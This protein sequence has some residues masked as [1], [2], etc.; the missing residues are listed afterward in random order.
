MERS[1]LTFA[2]VKKAKPASGADLVMVGS[3]GNLDRDGD[4]VKQNFDLKHYRKNPVVLW[5]HRMGDLPI[6]KSVKVG[7]VGKGDAK[8]L[9][10]HWKFVPGDVYPFAEAVKALYEGGFLNASSIGFIPLETKEHAPEV[11]ENLVGMGAWFGMEITKSELMEHSAVTVPS[12][13]E[14]LEAAVGTKCITA[15]DAN[16]IGGMAGMTNVHLTALMRKEI[17]DPGRIREALAEIK[18]MG[19]SKEVTCDGDGCVCGGT[20]TK[21]DLSSLQKTDGGII[22]VNTVVSKEAVQAAAEAGQPIALNIQVDASDVNKA[23][24]EVTQAGVNLLAAVTKQ[25]DVLSKVVGDLLDDD[26]EDDTDPVAEDATDEGDTGSTDTSASASAEDSE[27]DDD[28]SDEDDTA[29]EEDDD[30]EEITDDD[31]DEEDDA[32]LATLI[33][34]EEESEEA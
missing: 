23:A 20:H 18:M 13:R 17:T 3:T 27:E 25:T 11:K 34:S 22:I 29:D 31:F 24:E 28:T 12:N 26:T 33:G 19:I 2:E 14:S 7:T 8:Q 21:S 30:E 1:I 32:L 10:N 4:R 5:G 6:A 9:E 15:D 16:I